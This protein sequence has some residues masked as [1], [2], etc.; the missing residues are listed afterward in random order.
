MQVRKL[1]IINFKNHGQREFAFGK[2]INCFVG[3]NGVGKTNILDA[4]YY[5]SF[6]K[7]FIN[8]TD[9]QN[10][11]NDE[12]FFSLRGVYDVNG[13]DETIL[14]SFSRQKGKLM[15]RND[16]EYDKISDHI[17]LLP[18]VIISPQDIRL[19]FDGSAERRKFL[20]SAISQFN[21][22]HLVA[23][24]NYN[25]A[26]LQRNK[27]L[28]SGLV[29][30][31]LLEMWDQHL[32]SNGKVLYENRKTFVDD[33]IGEFQ[34]YYSLISSE[35]EVPTLRYQSQLE[36]NSMENILKESLQ[37]DI[38]LQYTSVGAHKDDLVFE[39]SGMSLKNSGSQG[40]QKTFLTALKLAQYSFLGR[41]G[42]RPILLLDDIFDKLDPSRVNAIVEMVLSDSTF[43]QIFITHT[44]PVDLERM[45]SKV[46]DDF[47]MFEI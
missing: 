46:T 6:S 35:R 20:D 31:I 37:K 24:Q 42:K 28:K 36:T 18:L 8:S 25:R 41:V 38:A 19:I 27:I 26:I 14:L 33:F 23:L 5:L 4:L 12:E 39:V 22:G 17:G 44:S 10:I 1:N 30:H 7:S 47:E 45:L 40:Q 13:I 34:K 16:K 29:D 32:I 2:K 15:K 43:G 21:N 11:R 3:S 9:S